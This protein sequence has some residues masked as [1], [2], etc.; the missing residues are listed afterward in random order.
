MS[1]KMSRIAA[2][3]I[4]IIELMFCLRFAFAIECNSEVK[5]QVANEKGNTLFAVSLNRN[6]RK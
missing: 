4:N 3:K 6:N 5:Q 2:N 1:R